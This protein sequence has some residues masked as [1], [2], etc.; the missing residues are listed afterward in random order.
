MPYITCPDGN[1]YS[2]YSTSKYV[3]WCKATEKKRRHDE[4]VE[5]LSDPKCKDE[6]NS[7]QQNTKDL[8]CI[9]VPIII[10]VFVVLVYLLYKSETK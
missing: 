8:L 4:L 3:S 2:R 10:T 5:C 7:R 6:Y 9:G 1:T